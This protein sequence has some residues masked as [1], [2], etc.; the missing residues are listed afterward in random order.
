MT[1]EI[2]SKEIV[3]TEEVVATTE[4]EEVI[5]TT[6]SEEVTTTTESEEVVSEQEDI[7]TIISNITETHQRDI[8]A[9]MNQYTKIFE[10]QESKILELLNQIEDLKIS[11]QQE[12]EKSSAVLLENIAELTQKVE[13]LQSQSNLKE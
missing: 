3:E 13:E 6:E 1:D 7:N 2:P 4:S 10:S 5:T 9:L 12:I 11:K 8:A